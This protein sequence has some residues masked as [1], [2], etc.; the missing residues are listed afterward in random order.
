MPDNLVVWDI[1]SSRLATNNLTDWVV[2]AACLLFSGVAISLAYA[3]QL[4][5]L[6]EPVRRLYRATDQGSE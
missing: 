1:C 5:A 2:V 4:R 6:L 3:P